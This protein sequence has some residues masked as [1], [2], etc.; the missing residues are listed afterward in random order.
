VPSGRD[1]IAARVRNKVDVWL[2]RFSTP[3][4]LADPIP[5]GDLNLGLAR[6][7]E[8]P[9]EDY[10]LGE[11][12][13]SLEDHIDTEGRNAAGSKL[14]FGTFHNGTISLGRLCYAACK[15][16]KPT[17]VIETGVAYGVTSAYILQALEENGA[18]KLHS[19]DLPPFAA[20]SRRYV[21]WLVPAALKHRWDLRI[22]PSKRILPEIV[23]T[24]KQTDIFIH[25]SLHTYAHMKWEFAVA[26]PALRPGGILIADDIEG[27]GAFE[28]LV[29]NTK[30]RSWFA[31]QQE[32]KTALCGALRTKE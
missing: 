25:D 5:P 30:V 23:G 21:G 18:G 29:G 20:D 28:E 17:V 10:F 24:V 19:V 4:K 13:R 2:D 16:L 12:L 11:G 9:P 1:E 15:L 26:L 7:F 14:P 31:M 8:Q 3:S 32:G 6:L 27:N 22:G